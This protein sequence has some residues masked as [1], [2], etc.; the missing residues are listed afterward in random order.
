MKDY[1]ALRKLEERHFKNGVPPEA[2][3]MYKGLQ[4]EEGEDPTQEKIIQGADDQLQQK[5]FL[6]GVSPHHSPKLEEF[7]HIW[8][9]SMLIITGEPNKLTV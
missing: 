8:E 5:R 4:I 6:F 7:G 2:I 3:E 1:D 9:V